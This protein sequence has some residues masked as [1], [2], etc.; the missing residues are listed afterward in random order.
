MARICFWMVPPYSSFHSQTKVEAKLKETEGKKR[1]D[2]EREE[3]I[4]KVWEWKEEYG[5]TIQNQMRAIGDSVDW[6]RGGLPAAGC[7]DV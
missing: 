7:A 5:G 2:Y 3:F 1:W 4:S 6:S